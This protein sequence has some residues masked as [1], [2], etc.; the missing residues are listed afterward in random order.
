MNPDQFPKNS[1]PAEEER[2]REDGELTPEE[3]EKQLKQEIEKLEVNADAINA[4][5][6]KIEA[7]SPER[8]KKLK[9]FVLRNLPG[10]LGGAATALYLDVDSLI[11]TVIAMGVGALVVKKLNMLLHNLSL[12]SKLLQLGAKSLQEEMAKAKAE[13]D[14]K[15]Y[16]ENPDNYSI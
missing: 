15:R 3:V 2:P 12:R 8:I 14:K 5:L 6:E 11:G 16:M 4:N 9:D 10:W 13:E 7:S 1:T